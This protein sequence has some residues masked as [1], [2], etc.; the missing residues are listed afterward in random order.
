MLE[1]IHKA[2]ISYYLKRSFLLSDVK[3]VFVPKRLCPTNL[4]MAKGLVVG[5]AE[6]G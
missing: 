4:I 1:R 6:L 3:H 5:I 2:N